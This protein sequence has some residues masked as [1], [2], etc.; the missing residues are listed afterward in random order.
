VGFLTLRVHARFGVVAAEVTYNSPALRAAEPVLK[1]CPLDGWVK[2]G[3]GVDQVEESIP[4]LSGTLQD[5]AL[6][7]VDVKER[8][9]VEG[10]NCFGCGLKGISRHLKR[11]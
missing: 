1:D 2:L 11:P 6:A 8:A 3:Q 10:T 5:F 7:S 9:L 4:K